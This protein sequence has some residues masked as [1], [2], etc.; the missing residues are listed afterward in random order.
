[1]TYVAVIKY[2]TNI[3]IE[4]KFSKKKKYL[5]IYKRNFAKLR[6]KT[7]IN[8]RLQNVFFCLS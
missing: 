8:F 2:M 6:I 7:R 3:E 5:K 1:M 4:L